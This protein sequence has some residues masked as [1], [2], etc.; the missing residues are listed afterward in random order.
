M[1][2]IG[3]ANEDVIRKYVRN[4]L[5]EMD[6]QEEKKRMPSRAKLRLTNFAMCDDAYVKTNFAQL[7][8]E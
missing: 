7:A 1:E 8:L 6:S 4:Q 3:N 2:T 5:K